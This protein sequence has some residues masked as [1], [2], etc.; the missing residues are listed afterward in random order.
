MP[1]SGGCEGTNSPFNKQFLPRPLSKHIGTLV[2]CFGGCFK[3]SWSE[4]KGWQSRGRQRRGSQ[5][6]QI[7]SVKTRDVPDTAPA[8]GTF[9]HYLSRFLPSSLSATLQLSFLI[10]SFPTHHFS[11]QASWKKRARPQ[12]DVPGCINQSPAT[13]PFSWSQNVSRSQQEICQGNDPTENITASV[14]PLTSYPISDSSIPDPPLC[15]VL[16][17][18][19]IF[20]SL[21]HISV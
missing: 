21:A 14:R 1:V 19:F 5:R 9:S 8:S 15:Q 16:L 17:S 2:I 11:S 6:E 12:V 10:C 4:A 20:W 13:H 3:C 18:C 7:S